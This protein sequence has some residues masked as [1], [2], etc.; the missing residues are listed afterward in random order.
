LALCQKSYDTDNVDKASNKPSNQITLPL[1]VATA[2]HGD[3]S[4]FIDSPSHQDSESP[5]VDVADGCTG[6]GTELPCEEELKYGDIDMVPNSAADGQAESTEEKNY[7][8]WDEMF[9]EL[10]AFK[11]TNGHTKVNAKSKLGRWVSGQRRHYGMLRDEDPTFVLDKNEKLETFLAS[12]RDPPSSP[13]RS[14]TSP[15]TKKKIKKKKHPDAPRRFKSA[16]IFFS[17]EKHQEIRSN[18]KSGTKAK[19][20]VRIVDCI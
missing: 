20:M 18:I 10:V 3:I 9:N 16:F 2:D 1:Q 14:S 5:Y 6:T 15:G 7:P 11:T 8:S 17:C 19:V 4:S 13:S 12:S